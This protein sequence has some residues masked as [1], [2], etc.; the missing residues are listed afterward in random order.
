MR[1]ALRFAVALACTALGLGL[2]VS[3]TRRALGHRRDLVSE[4]SATLGRARALDRVAQ[5]VDAE[6]GASRPAEVMLREAIAA[7]R[8]TDER[9]RLSASLTCLTQPGCAD[10]SGPIAEAHARAEAA[11]SARWGVVDEAER[12]L[13]LALP[14]GL[15]LAALGLAVAAF[16][17][18]RARAPEPGPTAPTEP[19]P[20]S[21]ALDA[22]LRSRLEAL[23]QANTRLDEAS[24]FAAFGELAAALTHGLKTPLAGVIASVQ[25]AQ[26]KLGPTHAAAGELDEVVRLTE[27]LLE[28]LQRFLRS[29]GQVGPRP[30][31]VL[32]RDVLASIAA[33]PPPQA[34]QRRVRFEVL[35]APPGLAAEVDPSLLDMALRNLVENALAAVNPDQTVTLSVARTE[36]PARVGL[37]GTAPDPGATFV[38]FT[39]DDEGPGLPEAARRLELG[40]TSRPHGSGLGLS[41]ARRVA[42]RHRGALL[43]EDR[44][45]GGGRVRLVLPLSE[46]PE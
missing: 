5:Q 20:P 17:R 8:T 4:L 35:P 38:A 32:L 42:E 31:R 37:E 26:L 12:A 30:R 44:P 34:Q 45:G 6:R 27:G 46:V 13:D 18:S 7:A 3:S 25:L 21:E 19:E 43:V 1:P 2:V 10:P 22:V 41:I 14:A 40:H 16:A 28:Q 23:Y 36:P 9:E 39:V 11:L 33:A 29:A 15:A 24:R